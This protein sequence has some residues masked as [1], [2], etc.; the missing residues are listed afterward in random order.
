M[1][2]YFTHLRLLQSQSE[3]LF[4]KFKISRTN[5]QEYDHQPFYLWKNSDLSNKIIANVA[6]FEILKCS[7]HRQL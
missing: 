7:K 4:F 5:L 3:F 6:R 2:R 1:I